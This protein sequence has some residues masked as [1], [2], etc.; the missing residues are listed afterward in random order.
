MK[1]KS[2][3][4]QTN[5]E[6]FDVESADLDETVDLPVMFFSGDLKNC[7]DEDA[8]PSPREQE[9]QSERLIEL[10][11]SINENLERIATALEKLQ[12]DLSRHTKKQKAATKPVTTRKQRVTSQQKPRKKKSSKTTSAS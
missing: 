3:A 4:L 7:N 9:Q 12:P 6:P 2:S 10:G 11:E 5:A 1:S 8:G